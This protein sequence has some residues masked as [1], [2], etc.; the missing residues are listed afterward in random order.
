MSVT[1]RYIILITMMNL[2]N[3]TRQIRSYN[4]LLNC[5]TSNDLE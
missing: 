5:V 3:S 2:G 4:A 1:E